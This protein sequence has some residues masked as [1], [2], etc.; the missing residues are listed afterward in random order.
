ML[1]YEDLRHKTNEEIID[2]FHNQ[3]K[4]VKY[5]TW[6]DNLKHRELTFQE[7]FEELLED[8]FEKFTEMES[9]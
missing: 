7:H 6:V 3:T 8:Y 5:C 1:Y 9:I 2:L 4:H